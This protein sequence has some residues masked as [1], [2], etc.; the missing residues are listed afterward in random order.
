MI[1]LHA[2]SAKNLEHW[3]YKAQ[4]GHKPDC[5]LFNRNKQNQVTHKAITVSKIMA[6]MVLMPNGNFILHH[7]RGEKD[8][9]DYKN[10][11]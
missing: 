2:T 1:K 3:I 4:A 7:K 10:L 8:G 5:N 6:A 11:N 9:I